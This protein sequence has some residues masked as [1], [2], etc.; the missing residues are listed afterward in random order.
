M[1]G[2]EVEKAARAVERRGVAAIAILEGRAMRD[3]RWEGESIGWRRVDKRGGGGRRGG[4]K[5][6]RR[7]RKLEVDAQSH[8]VGRGVERR[9]G[10]AGT[11]P[12]IV[13]CGVGLS[14]GRYHK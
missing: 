14:P 9:A 12:L 13:N 5:K 3:E 11:Y 4:R 7:N 1:V 10:A 2:Y 8:V 6:R